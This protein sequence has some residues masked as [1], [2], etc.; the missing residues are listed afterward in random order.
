MLNR[1]ELGKWAVIHLRAAKAC[2]ERGDV[3]AAWHWFTVAAEKWRQ[4]RGKSMRPS[5]DIRELR[6]HWSKCPFCGRSNG[7]YW[8]ALEEHGPRCRYIGKADSYE[9][10]V[11]DYFK[12]IDED[13]KRYLPM[14]QAHGMLKK[15][16]AHRDAA[17]KL[18]PKDV[19]DK[20]LNPP[21][22][23]EAQ[24]KQKK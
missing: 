14:L 12:K 21:K 19:V 20:I 18:L 7:L 24:Q 2:L 8:R 6:K 16:T 1:S 10:M 23:E 5:E 11:P 3:A 9:H 13:D 15:V 22:P 4:R 17:F